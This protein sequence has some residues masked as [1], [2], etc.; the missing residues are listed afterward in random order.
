[1]GDMYHVHCRN[2]GFKKDE[3]FLGVGMA[4]PEFEYVAAPCFKCKKIRTFNKVEE[5][6]RCKKCKTALIPY[7]F[8]RT[9]F[10]SE[11]NPPLHKLPCP[12]CKNDLS[13][14]GFGHWD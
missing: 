10:D 7:E 13:V 6:V 11:D 14:V 4:G 2:C 8:F 3:I 5:N 12:S 1:M 9:D